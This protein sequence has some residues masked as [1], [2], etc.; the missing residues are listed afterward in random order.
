M[1]KHVKSFVV[2]MM[3]DTERVIEIEAARYPKLSRAEIRE[4]VTGLPKAT[5]K[6]YFYKVTPSGVNFERSFIDTDG[7]YKVRHKWRKARA[8]EIAAIG[9]PELGGKWDAFKY[10]ICDELDT[11]N[12]PS[13][14]RPRNR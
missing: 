11:T 13:S 2:Y 1:S 5:G 4:K 14:H 3:L 12:T 8:G 7:T 6:V 9:D 10:Y